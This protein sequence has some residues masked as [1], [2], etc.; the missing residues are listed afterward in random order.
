MTPA[1]PWL[2]DGLEH[3]AHHAALH[4]DVARLE[5]AAA[6]LATASGSWRTLAPQ[7]LHRTRPPGVG[8]MRTMRPT[9]GRANAPPLPI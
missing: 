4:D 2:G 9:R 3:A 7:D 8:A 6:C 5:A 1:C